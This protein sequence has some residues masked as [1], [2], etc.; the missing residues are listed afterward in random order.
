MNTDDLIRSL[1]AEGETLSGRWTAGKR[2]VTAAVLSLAAVVAV[3]VMTMGVRPDLADAAV[4]LAGGAK[5]VMA[6]GLASAACA[7]LA[8][9]IEPGRDAR[10]DAIGIGV[11]L[12]LAAGALSAIIAPGAALVGSP[13]ECVASIL[14]LAILPLVALIVALRP[15][16]PTRPG[17]TGALAG[18]AAGGIAAFG[19]G[20]SCP[21]D[22]GP[23]VA[24][25][26]V[27]S[28]SAVGVMGMLAGRRALA[29]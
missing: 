5:F 16:A 10:F 24:F 29:W 1:A 7:S 18:L 19:Y 27:L 3:V 25:W 14:G 6:L 2:L 23:Y 26:Y 20:L 17:A 8:R 15:G 11:G 28:I 4:T 9:A 21:M 13:L 12:A 22:L